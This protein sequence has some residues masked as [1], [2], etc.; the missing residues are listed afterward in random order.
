MIMS[1][2]KTMI[3][4]AISPEY[5]KG[6]QMWDYIY[7]KDVAKAFY[8]MGENGKN[9]SIYC[10]ASGKSKPLYTY[11]ED[12]KNNINN[13]INLKLGS[14]PYSTKQVMSL[15]ADISNLNKDTGFNPEYEFKDGIKETIKWYKE[16]SDKYEKN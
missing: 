6:E 8:L 11:I 4:N 14:I 10:I 16:S 1:S 12:I 2:I 7:S 13:N 3:E 5:T 15:Y 9:N